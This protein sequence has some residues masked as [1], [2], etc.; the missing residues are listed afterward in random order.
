MVNEMS[1]DGVSLRFF[2]KS[3]AW[4]YVGGVVVIVAEEATER[5]A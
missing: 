2:R 1:P 4:G 5:G 3:G